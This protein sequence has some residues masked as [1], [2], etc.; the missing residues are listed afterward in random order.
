M[1]DPISARPTDDQLA[2][3]QGRDA[4]VQEQQNDAP[5]SP[6]ATG[7]GPHTAGSVPIMARLCRIVRA[8][9]LTDA[10]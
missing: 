9:K 8:Q 3:Q 7:A 5:G 6:R 4:I 2:L 10:V 1:V